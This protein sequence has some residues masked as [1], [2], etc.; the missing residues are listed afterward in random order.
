[1]DLDDMIN[2]LMTI[3]A[4]A[5]KA[6]KNPS[7]F[8]LKELKSMAAHLG[9]TQTGSKDELVDRIILKRSNTLR[10]LALP[11]SDSEDVD[12]DQ[13]EDDASL[14]GTG[15][16]KSRNTNF[17]LINVVVKYPAALQRS[18]LI[19]SKEQLQN[20][21]TGS[22]APFWKEVEVEFNDDTPTGGLIHQHEEFTKKKIAPDAAFNGLISSGKCYSLW[23][24]LVKRY[25]LA[26]RKFEVSGN[27]NEAIFWNFCMGKVDVLYL[28]L[29][30][31][32]LGDMD[33]LGY[34]AE[35]SEVDGGLE[36]SSVKSNLTR[37]PTP[38]SDRKRRKETQADEMIDIAKRKLAVMSEAAES[39]RLASASTVERNK[40]QTASLLWEQMRSIESAIDEMEASSDYNENLPSTKLKRYREDYAKVRFKYDKVTDEFV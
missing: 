24:N 23:K 10:I 12:S 14:D 20:R 1:M 29:V 9:L 25:A 6:H 5:A 21:E 28:R 32:G 17:R 40:A 30:L 11:D 16:K 37:T 4:A 19:A 7:N 31:N 8:S 22:R 13:E 39:E 34:C 35:G 27:G 26:V 36:T 2:R 33:L 38:S 18:N 15:F 3:G